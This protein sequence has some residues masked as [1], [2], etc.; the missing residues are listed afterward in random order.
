M[1]FGPKYKSGGGV[2]AYVVS[3]H[4][5]DGA[6]NVGV[7]RIGRGAVLKGSAATCGV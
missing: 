5:L 7:A 4:A 2:T 6:P 3:P 1:Q